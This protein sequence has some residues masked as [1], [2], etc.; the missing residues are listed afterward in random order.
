MYFIPQVNVPISTQVTS[1]A[2]VIPAITGTKTVTLSPSGY[3]TTF[4]GTQL[5][6]NGEVVSSPTTVVTGDNI[7]IRGTTSATYEAAFFAAV[8]IQDIGYFIFGAINRQNPT[9]DT[10]PLG[11]LWNPLTPFEYYNGASPNNRLLS[12]SSA[13]VITSYNLNDV[14][15]TGPQ[16]DGLSYLFASDMPADKVRRVGTDGTV[17]QSIS[18]EGPYSVAYTPIYASVANTVTHTL[19]V[20][21]RDNKIR[22]YNGNTHALEHELNVDSPYGVAG[23]G[24]SVAGTY[25]FWVTQH[26]HERLHRVSYYESVGGAAPTVKFYWDLEENTLPASVEVDSANNA[27]VCCIG[28]SKI[29]KIPFDGVTAPTYIVLTANSVP[30]HISVNAART[31]AYVLQANVNTISIITLATNAVNV[32]SALK[33]LTCSVVANNRL[34]VGSLYSGTLGY[35][36]LTS[37]TVLG[38]YTSLSTSYRLI[39]GMVT[40]TAKTTVY[41]LVQHEDSPSLI[42]PLD[43]APDGLTAV[44]TYTASSLT[45]GAQLVSATQNIVGMDTAATFRVPNMAS[46]NIIRNGTASSTAV[47]ISNGDTLAIRHTVPAGGLPVS[48][49]LLYAGGYVMFNSEIESVP[50][51]TSR[52]RVAGYM[53]GG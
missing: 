2:L 31:H 43:K 28:T 15:G 47:S 22:I 6:K 17:V 24:S 18:A 19:V 13:N 49:P 40:D 9:T 32:V 36:P 51:A 29:A 48:M 46:G 23:T 21:P 38:T 1:N 14:A 26:E 8:L 4:T 53:R 52:I 12:V 11:V 20:S 35:Y 42:A 44:L 41:V 25:G 3:A 39:E 33:H 50:P 37:N 7:A 34:Y 16:N 45:A 10:V 27:H 30:S 5:L